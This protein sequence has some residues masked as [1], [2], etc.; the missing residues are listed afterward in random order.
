MNATKTTI[1]LLTVIATAVMALYPPYLITAT[2][3]DLGYHFAL[4]KPAM[5]EALG[6]INM[7]RLVLQLAGVWAAAIVSLLLSRR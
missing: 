2:G 7:G 5:V 4:Q 3:T 6:S 1:L